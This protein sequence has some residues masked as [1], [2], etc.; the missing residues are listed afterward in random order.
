MRG[1]GAI[2]RSNEVFILEFNVRIQD[3]CEVAS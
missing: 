2:C 3:M 1:N